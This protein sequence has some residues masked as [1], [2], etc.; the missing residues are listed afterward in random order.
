MYV[1]VANDITF[2]VKNSNQIIFFTMKEEL[3]GK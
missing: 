3:F 1:D 2:K